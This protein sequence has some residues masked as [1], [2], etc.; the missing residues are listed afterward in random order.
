[1]KS[2]KKLLSIFAAFMMVVGLTMTNASA[3]GKISITVNNPENGK[4]YTAYRL[5]QAN[6]GEGT[7]VAYFV[8][9]DGKTALE[10]SGL[11]PTYFTISAN[12]NPDNTYN[13]SLASG[14]HNEEAT[15]KEIAAQFRAYLESLDEGSVNAFESAS[16]TAIN[17]QS[18]TIDNLPGPG[19]YF[20]T[21]GNGSLVKVDTLGVNAQVENKKDQPTIE[22]QVTNSNNNTV[23]IGDEV[24]FTLTAKLKPG[25]AKYSITDTMIGLTFK[26]ITSVTKDGTSINEYPFTV[27]EN[28]TNSLVL[29]FKDDVV[30]ALTVDTTYV[31]KYTAT[32]NADAQIGTDQITNNAILKF[33][34]DDNEDSSQVKLSTYQFGLTKTK[35]AQNTQLDGAEFELS[36]GNK[37]INFVK[38]GNVYTVTSAAIGAA[39]TTTTI[40]AGAVTIKGLANGEYTLTEIKA[41]AGY[42]KLEDPVIIKIYN[43]NGHASLKQDSATEYEYSQTTYVL[44]TQG[45]QLPSTGGM[46]TTMLY[47]VGGILMVGAAI[48]FVTNKRMKHN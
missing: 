33:G 13:V 11:A 22:K 17:D 39:D 21:T 30:N 10:Q 32:V 4:T 34:N 42:N 9:A 15:A 23:N 5:L 38:S 26:E 47:V 48:L 41:P 27:N 2:L 35:D 19:Y 8:D 36:L 3:A 20:V 24:E 12:Q 43:G 14:K 7:A 31:I 28:P 40:S 37:K 45:T 44:N 29:T 16:A 1:M 6:I 46:G 25:F 18:V